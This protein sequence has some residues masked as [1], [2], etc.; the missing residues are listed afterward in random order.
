MGLISDIQAKKHKSLLLKIIIGLLIFGGVY[1]YYA[2]NKSKNANL[3]TPVYKTYTPVKGDLET[4]MEADGKV[5]YKDYYSLSFPVSGTIKEINKKEGDKVA[6]GEIIARLDDTY[7]SLAV[8]KAE[9][10]L[11]NAK[12]NLNAKIASKASSADLN[13]LK[14]QVNNADASLD[15]SKGLESANID[16]A[17]KA[18]DLASISLNSLKD[19]LANTKNLQTSD[20]KT[21]NQTIDSINLE[22][23]NLK[24]ERDR[25]KSQDDL[26]LSNMQSQA[27]LQIDLLLDYVDKYIKESD[28]ILGAT[29]ENKY[30]N[31]NFET[32]LGAKNTSIKTNAENALR[33]TISNYAVF[34]NNYAKQTDIQMSLSEAISLAD[35]MN[36]TLDLTL[37]TLKNSISSSSFPDATINTYTTSFETYLTTL[38][39]IKQAVVADS[40][41]ISSQIKLASDKEA[42]IN[43]NISL[44]ETKLSLAQTGLDKLDTSNSSSIT[45]LQNKLKTAQTTYEQAKLNYENAL[46]KA[47]NS[48]KVSSSQV[49]V[50]QAN[51]QAKKS[52]YSQAEL[53]PYYTAI[54]E[55]KRN[56][57]EVQARLDDTILKASSDGTISEIDGNIGELANTNKVFANIINAKNIYIES[58]VEETDIANVKLNQKVKLSFDAIENLSLTGVVAYISD[59]STIDTSGIVTYKVKIKFDNSKS[60]VKEGMTANINYITNELK[61]VL[62]VPSE[63]IV[64]QKVFSL[65]KNAQVQIQT[66]FSNGDF[67]QILSGLKE[68]EKIRY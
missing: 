41:Q 20:I 53:A 22:L 50:T 44:L 56:L 59:K 31:D 8:S 49:S 30:K 12:A 61:N 40:Q 1:S 17:K 47:Q 66:G 11:Q 68:G 38:K 60:L 10:S 2:Y 37:Q 25:T 36:N 52:N 27:K 26:S 33:Q 46:S 39:T 42:N 18:M 15:L 45:S 5:Y 57:K 55:A 4:S 13:V 51:L 19:D 34:Q 62:L 32:Y 63:A 3:N 23:Q 58:Y 6:K 54:D 21:Q 67:T 9:I 43:D 29:D 64:G 28:Y 16:Q 48:L 24:K 14:E 7:Y 65:D 35:S